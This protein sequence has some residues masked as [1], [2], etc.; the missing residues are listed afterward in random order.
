MKIIFGVIFLFLGLLMLVGSLKSNE[1]K[2]NDLTQNRFMGVFECYDNFMKEH[3]IVHQMINLMNWTDSFKNISVE[4]IPMA[5][6]LLKNLNIIVSL[7]FITVGIVL[8]INLGV[9]TPLVGA[10]FLG[11]AILAIAVGLRAIRLHLN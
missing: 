3:L 7:L 9:V 10:I 11:I 5:G 6:F 4:N 2:I 1:T 8:I